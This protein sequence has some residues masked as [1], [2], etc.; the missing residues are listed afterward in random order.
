[1]IYKIEKGSSQSQTRIS[2]YID[3]SQS[4]HEI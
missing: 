4:I 2:Q 3:Y 1:M